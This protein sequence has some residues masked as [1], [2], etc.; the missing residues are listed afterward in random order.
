VLRALAAIAPTTLL[1]ARLPTC[2]GAGPGNG[3]FGGPAI[4]AGTSRSFAIPNSACGIPTDA[5][6][7]SLSIAVVP[8]GPL[9]Y[10]TLWPSGQPEPFVSTLNSFDGRIKSNAAIVPAGSGG[11]V[12][13]FATDATDVVIDINGYFAP[14][15]AGGLSLYPVAPCRVVDTRPVGGSQPFTGTRNVNVAGAPCG[16]PATARAFVLNAT[17][18]PPGPL[19]YI[20][21]WPH[22]Q[23][24]P[25]ASTLNA[26]D[27]AVTNNLAIAPSQNSSISIFAAN[28]TDLIL[29]ISGYF[30]P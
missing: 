17:V 25:L 20:T 16:I 14:L 28:P 3:P 15:G 19:G 18:V 13:A 23:P 8:H 27:G 29:D 4:A 11:A 21:M 30:A 6:S 7:Y 2:H 10:L 9:G 26:L 22:G 1:L 24:Q 5:A 12:S